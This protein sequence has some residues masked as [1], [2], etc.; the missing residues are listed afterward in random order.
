MLTDGDNGANAAS[1]QGRQTG[2][3]GIGAV[4]VGAPEIGGERPLVHRQRAASAGLA[5]DESSRK[6]STCS[7]RAACRPAATLSAV[8]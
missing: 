5:R 7:A 2:A 4:E 1:R 6:A 3:A 8:V